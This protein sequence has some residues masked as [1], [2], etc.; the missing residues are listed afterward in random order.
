MKKIRMFLAILLC[1]LLRAVS[2]L[3]HRGGTAM[4]GRYAMKL[5]PELLTELSKDVTCIAVTGTNGKTTTARMVEEILNDAG[6]DC[7]SNRSGAN[8]IDGITTEY[9]MNCTLSGKMKKHY[10]VIECDEAAAKKV[11]PRLKPAAV[12]VTNLFRDQLDRYGTVKNT[13]GFIKE[14]LAGTP[15]TVMCLNADDPV[16]SCLGTLLNN[17]AI[18]Y[19]MT[20]AAVFTAAPSPSDET[21]CPVCENELLYSGGIYS[22]LGYFSCN[23]CGHRRHEPDFAV[24]SIDAENED[25]SEVTFSVSGREEKLLIN[26]PAVYN[27]YNAAGACA[28]ATVLGVESDVIKKALAS[29]SCGFGRMEN[30]EL[31][32]AGAKMMLAKNP[33]GCGQVIEFMEKK[34]GP[35][36]VVICLN[37]RVGDGRDIS[38][39]DE[40]DF[41][42]LAGYQDKISRVYVSGGRAADMAD[43]LIR[44]GIEQEK[45]LVEKNYDTLVDLLAAEE[46]MIYMMPNY[47][48]MIEL[49]GA[50]VKKIGGADFWEG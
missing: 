25:S 12:I 9:V 13:L 3:L 21:K 1:K 29:F 43:R 28:A 39:I 11:F 6:M 22:Q 42:R 5:Y 10:S 24:I 49:R 2:R 8:L 48:S 34:P 40:T 35:M 50:I 7:F 46:N 26:Q 20:P 37:D 38:W 45:L 14:G 4:P 16:T 18:Y 23:Y 47:T 41:E 15:G 32:K 30:F 27:I 33:V 31:G 19:G 44:A 36:S 17:K